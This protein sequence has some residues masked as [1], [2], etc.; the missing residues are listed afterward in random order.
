MDPTVDAAQDPP[1]SGEDDG[2]HPVDRFEQIFGEIDDGYCLCEIIRDDAGVA[3]DYR[4]LEV[5]RNFERMTGLVDAVGRT[6]LELVPNLEEQWI[7]TYGRAA[8]GE[9]LRF[10]LGSEAMGRWFDVFTMPVGAPGQFGIVFRDETPRHKALIK[11]QASEER[12]RLLAARER[13][14]SLRFSGR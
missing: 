1:R 11:L 12:H 3:I 14:V 13:E 4:F 6:A 2:R 9:R 10:Q 8:A 5:N 7:R